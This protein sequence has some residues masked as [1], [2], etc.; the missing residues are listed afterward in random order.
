MQWQMTVNQ[1]IW[2]TEHSESIDWKECDY[3]AVSPTP[4]SILYCDP[5]YKGTTE[6]EIKGFEHDI[7]WDWVRSQASCGVHV[8]VSEFSAPPDIEYVWCLERKVGIDNRYRQ[9]QRVEKLFFVEGK[10]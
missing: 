9:Q 8:F 10:L 6:Y 1:L 7:F 3:R 4:G 2:L 5:P